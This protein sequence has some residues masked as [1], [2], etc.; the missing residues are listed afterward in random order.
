MRSMLVAALLLTFST[1]AFSQDYKT[2]LD[3]P[4]GATLVNLS[5]TER[6]E[7]DQDLLVASLRYEDQNAD[8]KALQDAINETMTKAVDKAKTYKDVKISTQ[9]YYVYP[10]DYDPN[11]KPIEHG[12]AP[13][14][15]E[16][17]WRGQQALELK[18]AKA[19]DLLALVGAL[20]ELG[21]AVS[22]LNYTVSPE[23]LEETQESLLEAALI[24][25]QSKAERTAKALGKSSSDLLQV[26]VDIGGYYPAPMM[27]R[28]M[29]MDS[30]QAKMEMAAPVAEPGQSEITLT[31]NAQA[32]L[33]R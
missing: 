5:A 28:G 9:Q 32:M 20:Q 13:R 24:K 18:S 10:Y 23:L 16:R 3:L 30:A 29:A 12:E 4:E 6:V 15:L 17:V 27:A 21:L 31:I 26:N 14:K 1:P 7:V 33:K 19:D 2:I 11:P 8:P 22:G 25:L